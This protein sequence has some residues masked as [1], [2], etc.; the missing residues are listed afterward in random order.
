MLRPILGYCS[1]SFLTFPQST[2]LTIERFQVTALRLAQKI[3]RYVSSKLVLKAANIVPFFDRIKSLNTK[4]TLKLLPI[5]LTVQN[6]IISYLTATRRN[7]VNSNLD[8]INIKK[9][10]RVRLAS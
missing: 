7:K 6:T 9:M 5:D 4:L 1:I 3:P 2:I 8:I 10:R